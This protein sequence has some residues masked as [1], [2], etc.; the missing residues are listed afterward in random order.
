MM[1]SRVDQMPDALHSQ[2]QSTALEF[3]DQVVAILRESL[4]NLAQQFGA[5]GAPRGVQKRRGRPPKRLAAQRSANS[6]ATWLI[7][8]TTG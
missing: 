2:I 6:G 7:A 1:K 3:A 8:P 4:R 5:A